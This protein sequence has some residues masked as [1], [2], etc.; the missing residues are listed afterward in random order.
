VPK[1]KFPCAP[2][3][4]PAQAVPLRA[5]LQMP[6][7]LGGSQPSFILPQT[8]EALL[9]LRQDLGKFQYSSNTTTTSDQLTFKRIALC[10]FL[11]AVI[12]TRV[13]MQT[14]LQSDAEQMKTSDAY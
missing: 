8:P 2:L 11:K 12:Y 9:I 6:S 1:G 3:P 10:I 7:C 13:L 4:A 14:L 5:P